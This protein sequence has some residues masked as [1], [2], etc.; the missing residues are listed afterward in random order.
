MCGP[1]LAAAGAERRRLPA[2][3]GSAGPRLP[4]WDLRAGKTPGLECE[5]CAEGLP[6]SAGQPSTDILSASL[7]FLF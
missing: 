4:R 2:L 5:P 7:S 1:E 6:A 3:G